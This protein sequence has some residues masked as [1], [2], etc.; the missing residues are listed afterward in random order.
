MV[1]RDSHPKPPQMLKLF[2]AD[3]FTLVL[4]GV[5]GLYTFELEIICKY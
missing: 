2:L 5:L 4:M 3:A 1:F